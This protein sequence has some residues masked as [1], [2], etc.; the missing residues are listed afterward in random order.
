MYNIHKKHDF[1]S[2]FACKKSRKQLET[3]RVTTTYKANVVLS[4]PKVM[5]V[6]IVIL[7]EVKHKTWF[8]S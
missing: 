1:M 4:S 5:V 3:T 7:N 8:S 6:P 2:Y